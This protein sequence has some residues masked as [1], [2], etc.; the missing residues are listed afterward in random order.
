M[1]HQITMNTKGR[2]MRRNDTSS[3]H[4]HGPFLRCSHKASKLAGIEAHTRSSGVSLN[5]QRNSGG[6]N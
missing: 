6:D 3:E 1:E 2:M 5:F 4:F